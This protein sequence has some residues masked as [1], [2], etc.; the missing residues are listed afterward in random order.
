MQDQMV[1]FGGGSA[2]SFGASYHLD[3]VAEILANHD[4]KTVGFLD[5]SFGF[6]DYF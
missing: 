6:F 2:G 1:I 5:S 3:N 4:I